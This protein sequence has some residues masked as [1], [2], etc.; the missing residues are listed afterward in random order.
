MPA[1]NFSN[2]LLF[3]PILQ[4]AALAY[5][6]TILKAS[7]DHLFWLLIDDGRASKDKY[8]FNLLASLNNSGVAYW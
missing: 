7:K 4:G 1:H 6:S 8:T 5:V 3:S 2:L